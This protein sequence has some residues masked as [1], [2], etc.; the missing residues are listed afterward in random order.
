ML[1]Y[2][3]K[4]NVG[5]SLLRLSGISQMVTKPR[6]YAISIVS[7]AIFLC[8]SSITKPPL[9]DACLILSMLYDLTNYSDFNLLGWNEG[10][11]LDGCFP[12]LHHA[13]RYLR[14][15]NPG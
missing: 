1:I 13:D 6:N 2:L 15:Y 14:R 5:L 9:I 3:R 12:V 10:R 8:I 4:E 7:Y 11:D